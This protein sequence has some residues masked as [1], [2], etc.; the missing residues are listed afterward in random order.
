MLQ[1]DRRGGRRRDIRTQVLVDHVRYFLD[2]RIRPWWARV[3][4]VH[5]VMRI[6][7]FQ[8]EEIQLGHIFLNVVSIIQYTIELISLYLRRVSILHLPLYESSALFLRL[9]E[10]QINVLFQACVVHIVLN[11]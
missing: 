3:P 6:H 2:C 8:R 11:K 10:H 5:E 4:L 9:K 7:L 1:T